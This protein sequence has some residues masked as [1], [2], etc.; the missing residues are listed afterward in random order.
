MG[1]AEEPDLVVPVVDGAAP[2]RGGALAGLL[3]DVQVL[4]NAKTL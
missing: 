2:V 1:L 3:V 4:A